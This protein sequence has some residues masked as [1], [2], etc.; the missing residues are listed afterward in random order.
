MADGARDRR[1][2][3]P[4]ILA[5][6]AL[7]AGLV[8]IVVAMVTGLAPDVVATIATPPPLVRAGLAGFAI[9]LGGRLLVSAVRRIDASL[10]RE[11]GAASDLSDANLGTLVRGVRLVFLAVASFTAAAGWIIGEPLPLVI[12]LV[13]AGVDVV[14]TSFLLLVA[15]RQRRSD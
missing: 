7:L 1:R 5:A 15:S 14:E 4:R 2:L 10:R 12:A 8:A 11:P 13:I 6:L 3:E 9:V